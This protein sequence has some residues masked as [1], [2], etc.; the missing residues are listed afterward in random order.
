M[1]AP[2]APNPNIPASTVEA[3]APKKR[4]VKYPGKYY[5]SVTPAMNES[6]ARLSGSN[7]LAT[8]AQIGRLALHQ[9]LLAND[10]IYARTMGNGH[11][12]Q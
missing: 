10:P 12:G 5:L 6:L 8:A 7:S 9:F 1:T 2:V 3:Q 11:G 4:Q